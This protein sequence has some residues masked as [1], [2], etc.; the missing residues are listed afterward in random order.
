[1]NCGNPVLWGANLYWAT[2]LFP[3]AGFGWKP[4]TDRARVKIKRFRYVFCMPLEFLQILKSGDKRI[5]S[6]ELG[7]NRKISL[8]PQRGRVGT[9]SLWRGKGPFYSHGAPL[10]VW[11]T[12]RHNPMVGRA[13]LDKSKR[14][15]MHYFYPHKSNT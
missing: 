9:Y 5:L 7:E 10:L 3:V 12:G 2:L 4:F 8:H 1:M 14:I 15:F 6:V 11:H 13:L